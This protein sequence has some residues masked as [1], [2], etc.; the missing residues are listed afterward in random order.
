MDSK[1]EFTKL[2]KNSATEFGFSLC[3]IT[4]SKYL[5]DN[6]H[7]FEEW[8]NNEYCGEMSFL[9]K[10]TDIR[11]DISLILENAKSVICC[12]LSYNNDELTDKNGLK[13]SKYA[14]G[15]DYHTVVKNKLSRIINNI[16]RISPSTKSKAFVDTAPIFE[17]SLVHQ[18]GLGWIGKNTLVINKKLGSFFFIGIIITDLEL[19][20]D[21]YNN[22]NCGD[23][24][25]CVENCPT[26]ALIKPY[27]IDAK[28]CIAYLTIE[29]RGK[30]DENLKG[31]FNNYIYG[32][33][34]CQNICPWN[35]EAEK[36][37]ENEFLN[38]PFINSVENLEFS[39]MR[40]DEF[41]EIF[42]DSSVKRIKYSKFI[43]NINFITNK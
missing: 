31:K 29:Y 15:K 3:G 13:I 7:F 33:D 17:K 41:N 24:K 26:G 42:K 12:L 18:S 38:S 2:I 23:C 39:K 6:Y 28:K 37:K 11:K 32:C 20:Y 25:L 30:I 1:E 8:I 16:S 19:V 34:I 21:D 14:Y 43:E 9:K 40:E 27:T 10:N 5:F 36:T 4:H 35:K 22:T